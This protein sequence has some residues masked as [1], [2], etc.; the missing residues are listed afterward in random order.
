M[1]KTMT[2]SKVGDYFIVHLKRFR[3]KLGFRFK[4]TRLIDFPLTLDIG[5]FL[6]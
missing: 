1:T 6:P 2:L 5:K 3:Q 4:N